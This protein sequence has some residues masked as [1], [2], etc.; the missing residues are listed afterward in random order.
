VREQWAALFEHWDVVL[1]PS[2]GAPAFPHTD[3]ADWSRRTLDLDGEPG[4]Y[5]DQLAWAGMATFGCLP[6]TGMPA[7][8]TGALPVGVQIIGPYLEDL[9]TIRV[10]ELLSGG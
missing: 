5:G 7:P 4:A 1:A 2:F 9:T 3:E 8:R 6:A 10:A